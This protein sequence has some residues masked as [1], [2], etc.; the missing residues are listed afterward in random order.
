MTEIDPGTGPA[1]QRGTEGETRWAVS[2]AVVVAIGLQLSLPD[3]YAMHPRWVLPSVGVALL[4]ATVV[5]NLRQEGRGSRALRATSVLLTGLL[6]LANGVSAIRLIDSLIG[7]HIDNASLLLRWGGAIWLANLVI[8]ALWY[9]ELDRGGPAARA[10][11]DRRYADLLFT[12]M[13]TPEVAPPDWEP[14][15]VDYFYLAFT[16]AT[17]FSPTDVLP[18]TRWAKLLMMLQSALSF[19][20]V[21]LV[22]ARAVNI[23][24]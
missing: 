5:M 19:S 4:A 12:Q 3:Q 22:I 17:A 14:T 11:G 20:L 21:I 1:W 23:L 7:G 24:N 10:A 13:A 15:F 9:W 16:N 2:A 6:S 8:F 18:L